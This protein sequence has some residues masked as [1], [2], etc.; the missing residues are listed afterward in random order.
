M[1]TVRDTRV[2]EY[3]SVLEDGLGSLKLN[4]MSNDLSGNHTM[5]LQFVSIFVM[6]GSISKSCKSG[7]FKDGVG[8]LVLGTHESFVML[9]EGGLFS[10]NTTAVGGWNGGC[11]IVDGVEYEFRERLTSAVAAA[12]AARR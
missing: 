11:C 4:R 3:E 10:F 6:K 7:L 5:V 1:D 8:I 12:R 9:G 2:E